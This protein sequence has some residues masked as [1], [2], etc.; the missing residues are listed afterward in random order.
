MIN[1]QCLQCP[2]NK[3]NRAT[4]VTIFPEGTQEWKVVAEYFKYHQ[5]RY[6]KNEIGNKNCTEKPTVLCNLKEKTIFM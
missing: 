6:C 2:P 5:L 4:T 3:F 1:F